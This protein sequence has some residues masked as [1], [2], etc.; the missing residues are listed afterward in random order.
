MI[1]RA[2]TPKD[3][4]RIIAIADAAYSIYV[5]AMGTKPAPMIADFAS[6][7]AQ[8]IVWVGDD[9]G[10]V[11]AYVVAIAKGDHM[12]LENVA[13]DPA[14]Q[15]KGY[16]LKMVQFVEDTARAQKL[17]AVELYTN[18]KMTGNQKWYPAI[19]YRE[20]D[21]REEDGFYRIFYRK[22]ISL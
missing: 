17:A 19:G 6:H 13:V 14:C 8:Q 20:I 18:I 9:E 11:C 12:H 21:R 4:E 3:V 22:Q 5:E 2:A 7:V 10:V 1:I 15:G 16:G